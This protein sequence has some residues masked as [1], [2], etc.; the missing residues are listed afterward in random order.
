MVVHACLQ[1]LHLYLRLRLCLLGLESTIS[2]VP[3]HKG[4]SLISSSGLCA[5]HGMVTLLPIVRPGVGHSFCKEILKFVYNQSASI[6]AGTNYV[7]DASL[8]KYFT[9][10]GAGR[11]R[12]VRHCTGDLNPVPRSMGNCICFSMYARTDFISN[13]AVEVQLISK[14]YFQGVVPSVRRA[15][16]ATGQDA[17]LFGSEY[18]SSTSTWTGTPRIREKSGH[19]EKS[20]VNGF[21]LLGHVTQALAREV[22]PSSRGRP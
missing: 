16:I 14:T 22:R 6:G 1:F 9:A 20:F 21:P 19:L 17:P 15:V 10:S 5:L 11:S 18:A 8:H 2:A 3:L 7:V 12:T 13:S 4:Q